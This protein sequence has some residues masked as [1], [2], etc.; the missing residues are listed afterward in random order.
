MYFVGNQSIVTMFMFVKLKT[1]TPYQT[2][3][4]FAVV[5]LLQI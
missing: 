5:L 1:N 4:K 3:V 2:F